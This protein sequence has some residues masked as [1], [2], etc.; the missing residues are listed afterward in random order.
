MGSNSSYFPQFEV[1][2][3]LG[4]GGFPRGVEFIRPR[5][6]VSGLPVIGVSRSNK[7]DPTGPLAAV[8]A[9]VASPIVNRANK[10]TFLSLKSS[11]TLGSVAFPV[12]SNSF[13]RGL[14][15]AACRSLARVGRINSTPRALQPPS[16]HP[17]LHP[18][19][20]PTKDVQTPAAIGFAP[21]SEK[22][23]E[24]SRI[25][26]LQALQPAKV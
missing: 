10:P 25:N 6:W 14:W 17:S 21:V 9:S 18:S 8:G 24:E 20:D 22:A 19:G 16:V 13:D 3:H 1:V 5:T 15:S 23:T 26:M 4:L 2:H 11:I 7:F 12:G